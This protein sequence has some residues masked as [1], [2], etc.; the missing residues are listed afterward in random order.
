[1]V[2]TSNTYDMFILTFDKIKTLK[3][4][5]NIE[6]DQ[7]VSKNIFLKAKQMRKVCQKLQ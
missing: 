2:T 7:L 5:V 6:K 3:I 1:M 4:L